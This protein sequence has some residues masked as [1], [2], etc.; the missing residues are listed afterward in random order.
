MPKE[1]NSRH[2]FLAK[3]EAR[4]LLDTLKDR[5]HQV[6]QMSLLSL[7]T[8]M[9]AGEIFNL[10]GEHINLREKT[11]RIVDP[12][13]S[14]NR[15]VYPSQAA[16]KMLR[17]CGYKSGQYVFRSTHGKQLQQISDTFPRTVGALGLNDN[18]DDP[19]DKIVF[20]SLRHTFASWMVQSDQPLYLV[21][22]L[23]GHSTLEMTKRYA[24]LSPQR[25]QAATAVLDDFL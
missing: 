10:R 14:K 25:K 9:R 7:S 15:T 22:E 2:R 20:H 5:S 12:K 8:G 23:M 13:S 24:H 17:D 19:R 21:A 6:W 4:L 3:E 16:I 1:D 11:I 18:L